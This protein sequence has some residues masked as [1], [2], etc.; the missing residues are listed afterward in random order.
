MMDIV[1]PLTWIIG[2]ESKHHVPLRVQ[3]DRVPSHGNPGKLGLR[4]VGVLKRAGRALGAPHGL[5]VVP[6]QVE[7]VLAGVDVVDDDLHDLAAL[8]HEGV[9]VLAVDGRVGGQ[10]AGREGGEQGWYFWGCVGYVVEEGAAFLV[11]TGK[12]RLFRNVCDD[13]LVCA[14]AE[15]V[16][17]DVQ[18]DDLV[19]LAVEG[20][21]IPRHEGDVVQGIK[22]L[23]QRLRLW[24]IVAVGIVDEPSRHVPVQVLRERVE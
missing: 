16:H 18:R 4:D 23:V 5:E 15:V 11:S 10:L 21:V 22:R 19:R 8:Q 1:D 24:E 7:G 14:I 20:L 6:V 2:P 13:V 3:H 9:R 12:K 17:D